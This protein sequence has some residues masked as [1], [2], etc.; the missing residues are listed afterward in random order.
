MIEEEL[1]GGGS[2]VLFGKGARSWKCHRRL[3]EVG[4]KITVNRWQRW[5]I[6]DP[7][8][9]IIHDP[10]NILQKCKQLCVIVVC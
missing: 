9:L 4:Y 5:L 3:W 8:G 7:N 1:S 2:G 10:C 6:D